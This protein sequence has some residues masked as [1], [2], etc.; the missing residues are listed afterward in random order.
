MNI[1]KAYKNLYNSDINS[2]D[3][4]LTILINTKKRLSKL[5]KAEPD[6]LEMQ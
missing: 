3:K 4:N 6:E 5:S 1:S 2:I